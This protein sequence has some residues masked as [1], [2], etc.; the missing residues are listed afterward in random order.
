[1]GEKYPGLPLWRCELLSAHAMLGREGLAREEFEVLALDDFEAITSDYLWLSCTA[2]L[3]EVCDYLGD[4]NRAKPLYELLL[5]FVDRNIVVGRGGYWLGAVARYVAI[6]AALMGRYEEAE[7]YFEKALDMHR[8]MHA[9][10]WTARTRYDLAR[11]LLRRGFMGDLERADQLLG[12]ALEI[13]RDTG[14]TTL[15]GQIQ[16]LRLEVRGV[17]IRDSTSTI[18]S[19]SLLV[20]RERP[21]LEGHTAPDG[22]VTIMFSDIE[23]STLLTDALGDRQWMEVLAAHNDIIKREVEKVKGFIVKSAGDGYMVA[24]SSARRGLA[25]AVGIQRAF[26]AYNA[27]NRDLQLKV[28]IGLHTGEAI[29]Q[30]DDFYGRNVVVAA[31]IGAAARGG[32]VLVSSVLKELTEGHREF[33]FMEPLELELKG[34]RGS[35]RVF[36]VDWERDGDS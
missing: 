30:E 36:P 6:L 28:R 9:T 34:L 14:M 27:D 3:A 15:V 13:A 8:R 4:A 35:H 19:V 10:P 20:Q 18:D 24:F 23:G 31:R 16:G 25:A 11:M 12:G 32:E 5:P 26:A 7:A 21:S 1:M 22:T 17:D 2:L 29:R 33:T